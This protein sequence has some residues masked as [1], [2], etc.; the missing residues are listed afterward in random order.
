MKTAFLA[1][2][3]AACLAALAAP[4]G[5]ATVIDTFDRPNAATLGGNYTV[6]NGA[7]A[8]S[9]NAAVASQLVSLATYNGS[10]SAKAAIDV[11]LRGADSGSYVALSFG[12]PSGSSYFVKVQDN[13]GDGLFDR[14]AFYGGNNDFNGTFGA[15][16]NFAAGRI[17]ASYA[18]TVATLKVMANNAVQTFTYDYGFAPGGGAVGFGINRLGVADNFSFDGAAAPGVPEPAAWALM[19]SG[20][21]LAGAAARRRG[22][23]GIVALA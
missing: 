8:I 11:A 10:S 16:S 1:A 7:F 22:R 4:A 18:G 2:F 21:G 5:A 20:F 17:E 12:Y 13:D 3:A 23:R 19:I 9:G 14:Y 6:E 15:L